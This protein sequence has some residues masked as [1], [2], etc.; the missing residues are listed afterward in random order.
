MSFQYNPSNSNDASGNWTF[1]G[2]V[3]QLQHDLPTAQHL[4]LR[5][6]QMGTAKQ[7]TKTLHTRVLIEKF[8]K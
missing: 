1:F 4:L 2:N 5:D 6:Y 7:R 3:N 8:R